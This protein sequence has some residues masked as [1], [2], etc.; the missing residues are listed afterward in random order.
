ML[1]L[2]A[3][4]AAVAF[5]SVPQIRGRLEAAVETATTNTLVG[6]EMTYR[7][8]TRRIPL[9]WALALMRHTRRTLWVPFARLSRCESEWSETAERIV[10]DPPQGFLPE[11]A[12]GA[13]QINWLAWREVMERRGLSRS[14]MLTW[15]GNAQAMQIVWDEQGPIAWKICSRRVGIR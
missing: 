3:L 6:Y 9:G 14:D 11:E 12:L 13:G 10:T 2:L 7:G 15:D 1:L 4:L 5:A 8:A